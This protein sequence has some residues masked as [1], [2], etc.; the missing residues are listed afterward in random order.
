M[1]TNQHRTPEKLAEITNG[2][3]DGIRHGMAV[4]EMADADD[5]DNDGDNESN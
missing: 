4:Y 2:D 3:S 1:E 5:D